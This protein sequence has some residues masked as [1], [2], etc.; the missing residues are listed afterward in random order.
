MDEPED[1]RVNVMPTTTVGPAG[2][3]RLNCEQFCTVFALA[4]GFTMIERRY[5]FIEEARVQFGHA[6]LC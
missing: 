5:S 2:R 1:N 4:W 3:L 6:R